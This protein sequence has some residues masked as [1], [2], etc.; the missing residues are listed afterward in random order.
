MLFK[1]M[2]AAIDGANPLDTTNVLAQ[3]LDVINHTLDLCKKASANMELMRNNTAFMAMHGIEISV[4]QMTLTLL[5]NIEIA[6][7]VEYGRKLCLAMKS[8]TR[9]TYTTTCMV[10]TCSTMS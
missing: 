10:Q 5:V 6:T 1:V 3:L 9:S 8:F 2:Q 4:P 7:K